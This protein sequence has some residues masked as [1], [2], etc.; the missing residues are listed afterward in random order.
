MATAELRDRVRARLVSAEAD[1]GRFVDA[2]VASA[3]GG[4]SVPACW[5]R[6]PRTK[7]CARRTRLA[8]ALAVFDAATITTT[9]GFC[10]LVLA[11]LGVAGRV[12][13][14]GALIE[15]A[16]DTVDEA[17]DDLFLRRVLGWGVPPFDRKVAREIARHSPWPTR[18]RRSSRSPATTHP[19]P[20]APPGRGVRSEVARRLLDRNLLTYD[21][22]LV[23][24]ARHAGRPGARRR[25]PA[26]CCE[27][28][29][30]SCSSTSS[31]TPT[32]CS[33]RWCASLR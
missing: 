1:L 31:R 13:V 14:R 22:L 32:R 27:T 10:Q 26:G 30:G 15:D 8:D 16:S 28:A 29:T 3:G 6:G 24:L 33:G 19:G 25:R 11:G 4:S 23:R 9:H 21:D 2:G 17:V 7:W 12:G 18:S 5:H 20:P